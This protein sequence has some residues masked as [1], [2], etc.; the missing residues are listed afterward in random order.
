MLV[1]PGPGNFILGG[2][3]GVGGRGGGGEGGRQGEGNTPKLKKCY[4]M[5]MRIY[6]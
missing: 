3:F 6:V 5:G 1:T 2:L 4:L